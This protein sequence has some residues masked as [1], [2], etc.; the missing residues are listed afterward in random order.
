MALIKLMKVSSARTKMA[1]FRI[2][3]TQDGLNRVVK[4]HAG[5]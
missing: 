2:K 5:S 3:M 4:P 1:T